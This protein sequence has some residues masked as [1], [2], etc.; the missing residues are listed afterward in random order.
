MAELSAY[1]QRILAAVAEHTPAIA[2]DDHGEPDGA[3]VGRLAEV[4][5][6]P[7][8]RDREVAEAAKMTRLVCL[9]EAVA[10][11]LGPFTSGT[12][13]EHAADASSGSRGRKSGG[14]G[15]RYK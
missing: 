4:A 5:P 6:Q 12:T 13:R 14:I 9:R 15:D 11:P 3:A 8:R 2:V 7:D 1:L 10:K